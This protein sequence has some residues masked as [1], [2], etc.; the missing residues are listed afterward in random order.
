M[1]RVYVIALSVYGDKWKNVVENTKR[2]DTPVVLNV[3]K[4]SEILII[5]T[6]LSIRSR[7]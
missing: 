5:K 4:R 6:T 7:V 3:V 1:C 2:G